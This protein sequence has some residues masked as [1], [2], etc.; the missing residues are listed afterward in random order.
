MTALLPWSLD[1]IDISDPD[2]FTAVA[3]HCQDLEPPGRGPRPH[4]GGARAG[5]EALMGVQR[6]QETAG[7]ARP[8]ETV[9]EQAI[10][11]SRCLLA[12][13]RQVNNNWTCRGQAEKR[14]GSSGCWR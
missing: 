5:P 8:T 1:E 14:R 4:G 2:V 9:P 10:A 12:E 3:G 7:S 6:G 13:G 11:G